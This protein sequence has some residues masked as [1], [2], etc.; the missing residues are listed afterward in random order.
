MWGVVAA[1][2]GREGAVQRAGG[3]MSCLLFG[4]MRVGGVQ[5]SQR[6]RPH[7]ACTSAGAVAWLGCGTK[8]N[9]RGGG[10]RE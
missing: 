2:Q 1:P 6:S 9:H 10:K 7:C 8:K 3:C 4:E 5:P